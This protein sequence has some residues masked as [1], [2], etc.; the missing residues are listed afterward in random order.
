MKKSKNRLG[1]KLILILLLFFSVIILLLLGGSYFVHS[2]RVDTLQ[3]ERVERLSVTTSRMMDGDYLQ[4][5]CQSISTEEYQ[6]LRERAVKENDPSLLE[7][8][9]KEQDL[10]EDYVRYTDLLSILQESSKVE[11]LYVQ[12][13]GEEDAMYL[14]D[15]SESILFLGFREPNSEGLENIKDNVRVPA[16][17]TRSEY[18]WL[19]TCTEPVIASDGTSCAVVGADLNMNDIM[20]ERNR[21]A[22]IM[23]LQSLAVLVLAA[24]TGS[25][26]MR[27]IVSDPLGALARDASAFGSDSGSDPDGL[28]IM[29]DL[30]TL[31]SQVV[32]V[33]ARRQDEIRDLYEDIRKMQLGIISFIDNL[34]RVTEEKERLG[35]E[36]NIA[37][38][39]QASLLPNT[40]PAF[41]ER[42]EFDIYAMMKP[43]KSVAGDFYDF[44]LI[45]DN[46]LGIVMAD[47]SGK[48]IPASLFMMMSKIIINNMAQL[49][50]TPHEVLELSNDRICSNND[51][52][53]FVTV[54]FGI[55]TIS[56][57]H[58]IASNAG[59]EYPALQN[60]DGVYELYHD[61]HGFVLGGMPGV[62][63]RDYEFDLKKGQTLFLYTD[64]VPEATTE[65]NVQFGPDRM[66]AALNRRQDASPKELV[67]SMLEEISLFDGDAPQFDDITML[68]I[69]YKGSAPQDMASDEEIE[70]LAEKD[71]D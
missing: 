13:I 4:K 69:R 59:H 55:L 34:T 48:G 15:P 39:I 11:Y 68:A 24:L 56:T 7:E 70:K 1:R 8:Y 33:P 20:N 71:F 51:A 63:Y 12:D 40:F 3:Q 49:N 22:L 27:K 42:D 62:H 50:L 37:N 47:V 58:I 41:P 16:T 46:H 45:D 28:D 61:R 60:E 38:Q 64:G 66:I 6:A 25:Y 23:L 9:L 65:D 19:C 5:L 43:A 35:T 44:F 26:Y 14:L 18:G 67:H 32:A 29:D 31:E 21:F 53:M 36:L 57:G 17:V 30:A 52:N 2:R 54:W 10:Y